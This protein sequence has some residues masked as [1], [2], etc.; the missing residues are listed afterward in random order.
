VGELTRVA[1]AKRDG[2]AGLATT[3]AP[4]R[5]PEAGE[6]AAPLSPRRRLLLRL[7]GLLGL[8]A[9][10]EG[11][12]ILASFLRPRRGFAERDAGLVVAG[13]LD[14]FEPGSVSAFPAGKF[15]LVRLR[16]GGFLALHRECTHLGCTVPWVAEESRFACPCHASA[17]DITGQVLSPP[18]PR[19]LDLLPVRIEN[20]IVKVD[21]RQRL[22]RTAFDPSQVVSS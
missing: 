14:R 8:A 2:P 19:P 11:A 5:P 13:P 21:T 22:R 12:W 17:F 10:A 20:G 18:A 9:L 3:K 7:W 16:D 6:R 15:Y 4:A 1:R